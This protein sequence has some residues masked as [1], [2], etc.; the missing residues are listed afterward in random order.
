MKV[1]L[2][3]MIDDEFID[4]HFTMYIG[5]NK[6]NGLKYTSDNVK[7]LVECFADYIHNDTKL[8]EKTNERKDNN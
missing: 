1:K 4:N 2:I 5:K 8:K 7:G 3:V 6:S